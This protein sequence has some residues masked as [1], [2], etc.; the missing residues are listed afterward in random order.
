M[1][2][3][4]IIKPIDSF[5]KHQQF[6]AT[7]KLADR[8]IAAKAAVE[9][10]EPPRKTEQTDENVTELITKGVTAG[11]TAALKTQTKPTAK[12]TPKTPTKP[13]PKQKTK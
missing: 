1:K 3:I 2:Y 10:P 5:L 4:K 13:K 8:L 9:I 12:K 11:I 6:P 7:D